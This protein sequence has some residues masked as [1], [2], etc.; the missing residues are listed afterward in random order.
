MSKT[1]P[2]SALAQYPS[3]LTASLDD[4]DGGV[5]TVALRSI[6]RFGIDHRATLVDAALDDMR[7]WGAPLKALDAAETLRAPGS[8]AVVTG[9]QAGI[10]TGPLYTPYKALGAIRAARDLE[11]RY[12]EHHFVAVF[13]IEGDDH[14]FDEARRIAV[15]DRS[16]TTRTLAYD[17]GDAR[18]RHVGDREIRRDAFETFVAQLRETM[19]ETEFTPEM[20]ALL[21]SA[22]LVDGATF[23]SG[24][25]RALYAVLGDVPLVVV[26]SRNP[27]LK[28][29]AQDVFAREA[30]APEALYE[31]LA[32]RTSQLNADGRMT[33]ITP[34]T[35]ALFMTHDGERRSVDVVGN[36]YALRERDVRFDREQLATLARTS[37]E[38]FS[39]N[40]AL[41]PIVQDAILPT[42]MYVGGPTELA[43][44][45][46][47]AGAYPAFDQEPPVFAPRPFVL[48][49][50]PKA[51]RALVQS[52]L[53]IDELMREDFDAASYVLDDRVEA[54]IDAA[55]ERALAHMRA[56]VEELA[57][58]TKQIDPTLEKAL[59][60]TGAGA[61][62]GVEEFAKRLRSALKRKSQTEIDRIESARELLLPA[63]TLQERTLNILYYINKYGVDRCRRALEEVE[64]GEGVLQVIEI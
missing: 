59:G 57:G 38:L 63:R 11:A 23:A 54:E 48:L 2:L 46:Q 61:E 64:V 39:P 8:Y 17:D 45:E 36:G 44:L 25:A 49:L 58:M 41:R 5:A 52:G 1:I 31:A 42:A 33:T 13:W 34:K 37:P 14:D 9:Q 27:R 3:H 7:A 43:Y 51:K 6:D 28:W 29:L 26:S 50:E 21:E 40:V 55:R 60:A 56:A 16:G 12:P 62:K 18:P 35:G 15:I 30:S 20:L 53:T 47:V 4:R 10:A 24:F 22:Y 32:T 19:M